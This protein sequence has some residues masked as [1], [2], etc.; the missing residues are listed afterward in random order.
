MG[1]ILLVSTVALV[2]VGGWYASAHY[3]LEVHRT[4]DGHFQYVRIVPRA[5]KVDAPPEDPTDQPPAAAPKPAIRV[6]AFNLDGL[7]DNRLANPKVC[8]AL[9]RILSR[10]DVVA[11]Q[12]LHSANCSVPMRLKDLINATGRSYDFI[13]CPTLDKDADTI[14]N[15]M[16]FDATT[17]EVDHSSVHAVNVPPGTFRARPLAAE[18]RV[19][20]PPANEAFTFA[21]VNV[22]VDPPGGPQDLSVLADIF[23]A[24]RDRGLGTDHGSVHG[25]D[26]IIMLGDLEADPEHFGRLAD[27]AGLTPAVGG[28]PTTTRGTRLAD[29]ILFDRRATVE[30]TGRWGVLDTVRELDL[31]PQEALDISSHLPVWAEFSSY[32]NGRS[33]HVN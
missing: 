6:A 22:L 24:E 3:S 33:S 2:C 15:A 12:D 18:F 13:T 23:L 10:F 27:V 19:R 29:N 17:V 30:Y 5:A 21:L 20:G 16:L 28:V 32:E 8:E 9:V 26:D 31:T 4:S 25:E 14:Y 7:D 11:L 1:R